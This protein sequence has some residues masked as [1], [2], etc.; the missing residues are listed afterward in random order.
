MKYLSVLHR[1]KQILTKFEVCMPQNINIQNRSELRKLVRRLT[2][3]FWQ[4]SGYVNNDITVYNNIQIVHKYLQVI[5]K[6][7]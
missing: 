2:T 6:L 3:V 1:T 7:R 5:L 4:I